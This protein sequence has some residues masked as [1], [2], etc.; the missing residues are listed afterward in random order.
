MDVAHT[1]RDFQL[2]ARKRSPSFSL[3]QLSLAQAP[4]GAPTWAVLG[5]K[6][7]LSLAAVSAWIVGVCWLDAA[8]ALLAFYGSTQTYSEF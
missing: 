8:A 2:G 5:A 7:S 1:L 3:L 6:V 4:V